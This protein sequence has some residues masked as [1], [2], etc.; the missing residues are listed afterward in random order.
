MFVC[1]CVQIMMLLDPSRKPS[2]DVL[3]YFLPQGKREGSSSDGEEEEGEGGANGGLAE[4]PVEGLKR[5]RKGG[6]VAGTG[7]SKK[8]RSTRRKGG[9]DKRLV[10]S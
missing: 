10:S 1:V 4:L 5:R 6:G 8:G 3:A 9:N 2:Q 7:Q